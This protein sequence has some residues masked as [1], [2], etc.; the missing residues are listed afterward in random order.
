MKQAREH[1]PALCA[2]KGERMQ[3][4]ETIQQML[5]LHALGRDRLAIPSERRVRSRARCECGYPTGSTPRGAT[6]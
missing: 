6:S 3:E 1:H 4:P 5:A 2:G